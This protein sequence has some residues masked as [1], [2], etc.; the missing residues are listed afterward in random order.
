ME[1]KLGIVR[2]AREEEI[3]HW[4]PTYTVPKAG[5]KWRKVLD[6]RELNAA[7]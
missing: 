1:L 7:T 4:N 6:C 2:E 5:G 3:L